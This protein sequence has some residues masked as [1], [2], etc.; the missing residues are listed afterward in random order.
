MTDIDTSVKSDIN[1]IYWLLDISVE[2]QNTIF[3]RR[4]MEAEANNIVDRGH[5]LIG[6]RESRISPK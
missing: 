5:I 6:L 4:L 3:K 2:L 1:P